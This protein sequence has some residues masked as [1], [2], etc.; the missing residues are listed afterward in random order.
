MKTD[1]NLRNLRI[2]SYREAKSSNQNIY[3][4]I[5]VKKWNMNLWGSNNNVEVIAEKI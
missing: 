3:N 2:G 4:F 1:V 5:F